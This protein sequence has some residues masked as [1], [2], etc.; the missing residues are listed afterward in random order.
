MEFTKCISNNQL[1]V[2]LSFFILRVQA[3]E[4]NK[5]NFN[6]FGDWKYVKHYAWNATEYGDK[7]I[8]A[9]K[10]SI[11]HIDAHNLGFIGSANKLIEPCRYSIMAKRQFF[12]RQEK[13]PNFVEDRALAIIYKKDQLSNIYRI[14]LNCKDNC[15]SI[16][17]LKQDTL[18]LNYCGGYTFL[19][20][21]GTQNSID[22]SE[23]INNAKHEFEKMDKEHNQIY[24]NILYKFKR[25]TI[26]IHNM[27][28]AQRQWI[29]Y[30]D[31]QVKMKFPL[32]PDAKENDL[33]MCRYYYLKELTQTR[34]KEL[35]PWLDEVDGENMCSGSTYKIV[36]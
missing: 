22:H 17:Y 16:I 12:D 31:A 14:E 3:Q 8:D 34:I 30:R 4:P 25:D 2:F 24:Q 32:Y 26:F 27:K 33:T 29:K 20:I 9:I 6:I 28:E 1:L 36:K 35:Q 18:I 11:L 21:K 7:E 5:A 23:S 15:M 13:E 10:T 19:L